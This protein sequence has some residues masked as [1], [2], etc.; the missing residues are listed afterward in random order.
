VVGWTSS[1]LA[2]ACAT[3]L[4]V[5]VRRLLMCVWRI[6]IRGVDICSFF[7]RHRLHS[8]THVIF[9]VDIDYIG[10]KKITCVFIIFK[11]EGLRVC[12]LW[13]IT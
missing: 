1:A 2:R 5:F 8:N 10:V 9:L 12:D 3:L 4:F 7:S 13:G 6:M 11:V